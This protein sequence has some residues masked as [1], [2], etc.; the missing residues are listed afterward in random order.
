MT[1]EEID[2]WDNAY[3]RWQLHHAVVFGWVTSKSGKTAV[4]DS[5]AA[6]FVTWEP[7]FAKLEPTELELMDAT[8]FV[9]MDTETYDCKWEKHYALLRRVILQHRGMRLKV[10]PDDA[11][12][13]AFKRLVNQYGMR[14]AREMMEEQEPGWSPYREIRETFLNKLG[15]MPEQ[16]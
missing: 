13:A 15:S 5:A 7:W 1:Q 9:A 4:A 3:L 8:E 12:T 10:H 16:S 14:K 6:L 11:R 2:S